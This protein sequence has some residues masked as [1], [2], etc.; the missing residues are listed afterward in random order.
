MCRR[1]Q[2]PPSGA[3][4][5]STHAARSMTTARCKLRSAS[6]ASA[7]RIVKRFPFV[8]RRNS[9]AKLRTR[10]KL[11][12]SAFNSSCRAVSS[13]SMAHSTRRHGT[14]AGRACVQE[15]GT[16]HTKLRPARRPYACERNCGNAKTFRRRSGS[17]LLVSTQRRSDGDELRT[18]ITGSGALPTLPVHAGGV[19]PLRAAISSTTPAYAARPRG[20]SVANG[21]AVDQR[22]PSRSA[23]FAH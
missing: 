13:S 5:L 22:K 18:S 11:C 20:V 14:V 8:V 12:A 1:S 19:S 3:C 23:S 2:F 10:W 4:R 7:L 6:H 15:R 16:L 9:A 17:G 21:G